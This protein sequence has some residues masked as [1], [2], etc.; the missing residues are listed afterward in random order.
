MLR[1]ITQGLGLGRITW[2]VRGLYR[3]GSLT[4]IAREDHYKD[5]DVSGRVG[6][7]ILKWILGWS[8][9]DLI[10][11]AYHR[12]QWRYLCEHGKETL[13]FHKMFENS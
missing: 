7:V 12:A 9:I 10:H 4:R 8:G 13:G 3:E 2:N 1:N 6:R 11:L 5:L